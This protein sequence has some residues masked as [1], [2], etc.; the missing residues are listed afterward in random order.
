M[1]FER[2]RDEQKAYREETVRFHNGETELAGVLC[3]PEAAGPHPVIMFI[4][5][6]GPAG[7]DG[8]NGFPLLWQ[9]FA[10][11]GCACLSWDKP[12]VGESTGD[13]RSQTL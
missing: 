13:W 1:S 11:R 7:R 3:L 12:G 6:S 8:Y 2:V 4:H 9:T 5:G 10:R